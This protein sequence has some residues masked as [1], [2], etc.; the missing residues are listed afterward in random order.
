MKHISLVNL[1][2][3]GYFGVEAPCFINRTN[4]KHPF[5]HFFACQ[6]GHDEPKLQLRIIL[7]VRPLIYCRI[8]HLRI[9][10]RLLTGR[11]LSLSKPLYNT[12]W[13][14]CPEHIYPLQYPFCETTQHQKIITGRDFVIPWHRGTVLVVRR[15]FCPFL[16]NPDITL[17]NR[18]LSFLDTAYSAPPLCF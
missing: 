7:D 9:G 5:C 11:I 3:F 8:G 10:H 4:L 1:L 6:Y 15:P 18:F 13:A 14:R 2:S 17:L 12:R 16:S